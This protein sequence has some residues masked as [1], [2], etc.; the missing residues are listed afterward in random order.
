MFQLSDLRLLL[1]F[2]W[3]QPITMA[4]YA[5]WV[6]PSF[7]TILVD[8]CDDFLASTDRGMDKTRTKLITQVSKDI[9]VI[10]QEQ[11]ETLPND[12]EKVSNTMN[13][14]LL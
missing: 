5:R 13:L 3:L 8:N 2:T 12:L 14:Q 9:T 7:R 11:G 6:V 4:P 10:A 1:I